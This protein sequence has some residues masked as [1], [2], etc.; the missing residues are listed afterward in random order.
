[1]LSE[2]YRFDEKVDF[3]LFYTNLVSFWLYFISAQ[4]LLRGHF[5]LR[6][7][8]LNFKLALENSTHN[9][10]LNQYL[11]IAIKYAKINRIS[12]IK[13]GGKKISIYKNI[14]KFKLELALG[15]FIV[16]LS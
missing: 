9:Y 1:M 10:P 2:K 8:K 14:D 5:I 7:G 16:F 4:S 3:S 11:T 12:V 13:F 6:K 15:H